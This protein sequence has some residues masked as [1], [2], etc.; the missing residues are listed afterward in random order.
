MADQDPLSPVGFLLSFLD[1][2]SDLL[3]VQVVVIILFHISYFLDNNESTSAV[4][5]EDIDYAPM[6]PESALFIF[7]TTNT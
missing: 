3:C 4:S 5:T 7:S 2:H 6:P 1:F